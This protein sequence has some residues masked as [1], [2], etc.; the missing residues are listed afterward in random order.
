MSC[1]F[2][3][4][5]SIINCKEAASNLV[6]HSIMYRLLYLALKFF[7][8]IC[9]VNFG[10]NVIILETCIGFIVRVNPDDENTGLK[11]MLLYSLS[12]IL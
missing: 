10:Q 9:C 1:Y 12:K 11:E 3:F 7:Q 4:Y 8:V 6:Y 2:H 5:I